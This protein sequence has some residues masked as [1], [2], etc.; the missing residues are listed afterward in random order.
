MER[1]VC[2]G[3]QAPNSLFICGGF[4]TPAPSYLKFRH[5]PKPL[6]RYAVYQSMK[7]TL[8]ATARNRRFQV[9]AALI[10]AD[11]LVFGTVNPQ[12]TSA[13]WLIAGYIMLAMT[14]FALSGLTANVFRSYGA[15]AHALSRR[16]AR[17][18]ATALVILVGLQSVGQ[19]TVKDVVTL[20]PLVVG[21]YLYIGY[22]KKT[23]AKQTA[24]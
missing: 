8:H 5:A 16:A 4:G 3:Y 14:V 22:G 23:A 1:S 19:L 10:A 12:H 6:L 21:V 17:Y 9:C 18:G 7:Q 24:P 13:L 2:C 15:T 11:C 20:L